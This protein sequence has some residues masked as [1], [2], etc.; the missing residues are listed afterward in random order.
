MKNS[1]RFE[2]LLQSIWLKWN[3]YRSEFH[4]TQSYV[5]ASSHRSEIPNQLD[6]SK[7]IQESNIRVKLIKENS[8]LFAEIICKYFNES[9]EESIFQ[10]VWNQQM[11]PQ[12]SKRVH[13]PQKIIIDQLVFCQFCVNYLNDWL[14]NSVQSFL[15]V[16]YQNFSVV[17]GKVMVPNTVF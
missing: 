2:I 10:I 13:V 8:D 17:L 1:L 16:Y 11:L 4:S 15:K 6:S 5:S 12:S 7:A 3:L 9:L 14:S